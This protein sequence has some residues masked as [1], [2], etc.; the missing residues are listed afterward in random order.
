LRG[1]ALDKKPRH[2]AEK[3]EGEDEGDIIERRLRAAMVGD[4]RGVG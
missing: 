2:I 4:G 1:Y 3:A